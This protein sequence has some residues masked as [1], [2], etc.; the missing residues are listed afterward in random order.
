[1]R[2][3]SASQARFRWRRG[4]IGRL[5]R[6][7]ISPLSR[8]FRL[9]Q[10]SCIASFALLAVSIA[11]AQDTVVATVDGKPITEADVR[12]AEAEIGSELTKLP[13]EAR[14][15]LLVE[16]LIENQV[17]AE[18]G[19]KDKL[20]DTPAFKERMA[21]WQRRALRETFFDKSVRGPVK[22]D[23]ARQFY[24]KQVGIVKT[25]S[26]LRVRHI[27]VETEDLVKQLAE[28][29]AK[30]E[31]FA[32]LAKEHSR[33]P[34]SK[35]QGGELGFFGRGQMVPE[36]EEAAFKLKD[37]EISPPV[38]SKFGWHI[39]K[40]EER[41]APQV[42][43]FEAVKQRIMDALVQKRAQQVVASLREA[44]K[45]E[46]VDPELKKMVEKENAIQPAPGDAPGTGATPGGTP[47][48][49]PLPAPAPK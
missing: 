29:I 19:A 30:G 13:P 17:L 24:D 32:A 47:K 20:T 34:G 26:E 33:D 39:I 2:A 36:F 37:G 48:I 41:R 45:V 23:E 35:D 6:E 27:L 10:L 1:M 5:F 40:V 14:R 18:A 8:R 16:F 9:L 21:Y 22:E 46:F 15:R 3:S 28:K 43:P 31:D 42:V 12:N 7:R 11:V 4:H 49:V 25:Q 38:R 44:A